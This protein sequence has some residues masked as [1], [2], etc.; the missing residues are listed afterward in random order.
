MQYC[1]PKSFTLR[2]ITK[3]TALLL[4][5]FT[6]RYFRQTVAVLL[7]LYGSVLLYCSRQLSVTGDE[8]NYFAYAVN[9]VK[10][11]PEKETVNGVP[12]FNSQQPIIV[13]NT[14]PRAVEQVF[15][16][17]LVRDAEAAAY[18]IERGR[19]FSVLCAMLLGLYVAVWAM[20]LYGR[21]AGLFALVLYMLCPN[22]LAHSAFVSTDVFS[23]LMTAAPCYH[24]WRFCKNGEWRHFILMALFLGIAQVT[25]QSLLLLY[26]VILL[27]LLAGAW[28]VRKGVGQLVV[29]LLKQWSLIIAISL[30]IIN[31]AFLF[32]HSGRAFRDYHFVSAKFNTMQQKAGWLGNIP[33]PL[34]EPYVNGFDAVRFNMETGPGIDGLSSYGSCVFMG[35]RITTKRILSY[36][37]LCLLYKLPLPVILL[38]LVTMILYAAKKIKRA[39]VQDEVFLLLPAAFIFFSFCLLN[40]MYLGV[41]N[42]LMILPLLFIFCSG[43]I[44]WVCEKTWRLYTIAF[45]LLWQLVSVARFFPDFVPYT[46]ELIWNKLDTHTI[47]GDGNIY[48]QEGGKLL[49]AYLDKH[50]EIQYEPVNPVHGK[51]I[52]SIDT[53]YDWWNKNDRQWFR[54]LHLKP[55]GHFNS[56][57]LIFDVP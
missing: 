27:L 50:P 24:A 46:N 47:L 54:A 31:A 44:P 5:A 57:Y 30:L 2:K 43:I 35:E 21:A 7:L 55:V 29:S 33:L 32:R 34:P 53:Y 14:I 18:D 51:V 16:P 9:V 20:Q 38:L 25:K 36:Y 42:I 40:T 49:R 10:G 11:H 19:F 45:L 37:P 26:P 23:F 6:A 8:R 41:K 13:L 15:H 17:G 52:M 39:F 22:I 56:Q 1:L 12:V 3:N 48:M 4:S 28:C